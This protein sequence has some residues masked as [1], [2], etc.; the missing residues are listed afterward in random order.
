[1]KSL[2]SQLSTFAIVT[3]VT[4]LVWLYAEDANINVYTDQTV[5]IEFQKPDDIAGVLRPDGPLTVILVFNGSNGQFQQFD[6]KIRGNV[7]PVELPIDPQMDINTIEVDIREQLEQQLFRDLGINLVS[8]SPEA[9]PVTFEKIVDLT[10]EVRL[11][12]STGSINLASAQIPN[13]ADRLITVRLPAS[14][15]KRLS[16]GFAVA[17][18]RAADVAS[19]P[20]GEPAQLRLP[21]QLPAGV[22][23]QAA[24]ASD[25]GVVVTVADDRGTVTIDR[26]PILLS[27]PSSINERFTVQIPESERFITAFELEGPK[28]QIDRLKADPAS[29][30]VWASV[31]LTNAEVDE[32]A[33]NGGELTKAVD[34]IAP[35]G[36][37]LSSD[38]VRVTVRVTPRP[39]PPA[40]P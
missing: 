34:I 28:Q 17:R 3:I 11:L 23:T 5:R 27:Y 13:E 35:P 15:A 7:I 37:V 6:N 25:V 30:R 20:K 26:R 31:R 32:A 10:L 9:V 38:V 12:T 8:V 16:D 36:V 24:S 2:I 40:T 14:Q 22:P 33:A 39:T 29:S 1:M 19:L 21:I 4:V 18:I